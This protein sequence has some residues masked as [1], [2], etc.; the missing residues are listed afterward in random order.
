MRHRI[1]GKKLGMTSSHRKSTFANLATALITHEQIRTTLPKAKELKRVTDRLIT[2]AKTGTTKQNQLANR[3]LAM[4]RLGDAEAVR[5]MWQVL[6]PRYEKRNGGYTR[7]LKMGVRYGD[8]APMA[9]V[10]LI[11]RDKEAKGKE[12]KARHQA[13]K[14]AQKEAQKETEKQIAADP[15]AKQPAPA[16][17]PSSTP[18][19]ASEDKPGAIGRAISKVMGKSATA[20]QSTTA[21]QP[22]KKAKKP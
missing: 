10:E 2:L 5:K 19:Q 12:D 6:A 18:S 14:Q 22:P 13:L 15:Q 4:A 17:A 16:A 3:R 20:K 8:C 21:S 7:V 11:D 1:K 9:V